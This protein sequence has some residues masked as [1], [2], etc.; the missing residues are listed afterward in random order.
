MNSLDLFAGPLHSKIFLKTLIL[1]FDEANS[2]SSKNSI[3]SRIL[4][5]CARRDCVARHIRPRFLTNFNV[6]IE[7][8]VAWPLFIGTL[9]LVKTIEYKG[10]RMT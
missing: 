3:F 2:T 4:E 8:S 10:P 9:I 5:H 1:A 7:L 6:S